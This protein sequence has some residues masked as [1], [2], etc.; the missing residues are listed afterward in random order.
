M[1][2]AIVANRRRGRRAVGDC[3]AMREVDL[4]RVTAERMAD[5]LRMAG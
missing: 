4:F 3:E 5:E 2:A 1:P